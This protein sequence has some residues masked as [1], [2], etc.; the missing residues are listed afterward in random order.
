MFNN[1]YYNFEHDIQTKAYA[2]K[3]WKK[4]LWPNC[5]AIIFFSVISQMS[6][7]VG[8][9]LII[10]MG[11]PVQV[12]SLIG[13]WKVNWLERRHS[14]CWRRGSWDVWVHILLIPEEG[15]L[16]P[17]D[18]KLFPCNC[19]QSKL[20]FFYHWAANICS[21]L[22]HIV[23]EHSNLKLQSSKQSSLQINTKI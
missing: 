9:P 21:G 2:I 10:R 5:I 12:C 16:S 17:C 18:W 7:M 1:H 22:C 8:C 20:K 13:Y 15:N 3:E 6:K 11:C 14:V 4:C 19:T 23:T